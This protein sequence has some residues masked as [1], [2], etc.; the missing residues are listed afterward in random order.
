MRGGPSATEA[1]H[2]FP[3][4]TRPKRGLSFTVIYAASKGPLHGALRGPQR[5]ALRR[6]RRGFMSLFSAVLKLRAFAQGYGGLSPQKLT[7]GA[8]QPH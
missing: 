8:V 2:H 6:C 1:R 4:F 5:G 3:R 7:P